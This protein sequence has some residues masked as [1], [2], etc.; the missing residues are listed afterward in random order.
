MVEFIFKC[1]MCA[2]E[3][4][5]EIS[6]PCPR[7]GSRMVLKNSYYELRETEEEVSLEPEEVEDKG[8]EGDSED[9]E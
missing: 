3:E 5:R 7:C 9:P 8:L 2:W 1:L 6:R 4:I